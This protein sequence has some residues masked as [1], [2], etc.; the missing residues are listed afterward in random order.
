MEVVI[1]V[2]LHDVGFLGGPLGLAVCVCL[3][4]VRDAWPI[5]VGRE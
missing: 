1:S 5:Y 2:K 3:G 4:L